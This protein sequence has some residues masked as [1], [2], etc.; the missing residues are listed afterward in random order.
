MLG[1]VK[2]C[3]DIKDD[4]RFKGLDF[5]FYKKEKDAFRIIDIGCI[6]C[7]VG[8]V[9]DVQRNQWAIVDRTGSLVRDVYLQD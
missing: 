6:E 2:T 5:H 3:E 1:A 4:P 8:S 7:L 9:R